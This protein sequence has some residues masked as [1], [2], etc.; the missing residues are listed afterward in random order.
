M[1]INYLETRS[2]WDNTSCYYKIFVFFVI[3]SWV[4][5][6]I[7]YKKPVL[8]Y[9]GL[10]AS[11]NP[12]CF[13]GVP[14]NLMTAQLEQKLEL[15]VCMSIGTNMTSLRVENS[16]K[17]TFRFSPIISPLQKYWKRPLGSTIKHY[18]VVMYRFRSRLVRLY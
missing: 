13:P 2:C 5:N 3:S 9:L 7:Y 8:L 18:R 11:P 12:V 16:A 10:F 15:Q 1:W 6:L 17:T 14:Y 4:V